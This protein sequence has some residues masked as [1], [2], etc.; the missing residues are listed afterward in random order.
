MA[1]ANQGDVDAKYLEGLQTFL[2]K[3]DFI[4][5]VDSN[6]EGLLHHIVNFGASIPIIKLLLKMGAKKGVVN[7]NGFTPLYCAG[8]RTQT[9]HMKKVIEVLKD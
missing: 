1:I 8:L 9:E 2:V 3:H 6:G 4:H 7:K 5:E